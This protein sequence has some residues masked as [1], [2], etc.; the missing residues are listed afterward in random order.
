M[1]YSTLRHGVAPQLLGLSLLLA[2]ALLVQAVAAADASNSTSSSEGSTN[3][4]VRGEISIEHNDN[5][6][7]LST[8]GKARLAAAEPVNIANGRLGDMDATSDR[9]LSPRI[10]LVYKTKK[11]FGRKA[12]VDAALSYHQHLRSEDASYLEGDVAL[13]R[14][15]GEN[16]RLRIRTEFTADRFR[17]NHLAEVNDLNGNIP[18]AERTYARG[19]YTE[20]EPSIAYRHRIRLPAGAESGSDLDMHLIL[21]GIDRDFENPFN[22]R[23]RDGWFGEFRLALELPANITMTLACRNEDITSPGRSETILVD[24]TVSGF[25][26]DMNADGRLKRNAPLVTRVDR[27]QERRTLSV[28]SALRLSDDLR[29]TLEFSHR[30]P[31]TAAT[32]PSTLATLAARRPRN[33]PRRA[34]DGSSASAG[35]SPL[36]TS[37]RT[38]RTSRTWGA[39][40]T[41]LNR[42]E[43]A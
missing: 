34:C 21:G 39:A 3:P 8:S 19:I 4:Q 6:F 36:N 5:V 33:G 12:T 38:V 43:S 20:I 41:N 24:E 11:I 27:S 22:N 35:F 13:T 42:R 29:A 10:E 2:C 17:S 7:R 15:L 25:N 40:R 30:G 1:T 23:D 28:E 37:A 14:A 18:L 26:Q 9:V 31:T 16:G 32:I